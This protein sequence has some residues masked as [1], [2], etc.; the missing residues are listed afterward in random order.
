MDRRAEALDTDVAPQAGARGFVIAARVGLGI[1]VLLI[2]V[3]I[4]SR[5]TTSLGTIRT[6]SCGSALS[7]DGELMGP[8]CQVRLDDAQHQLY[9]LDL[10]WLMA[11]I[12]LALILPRR[13]RRVLLVGCLALGAVVL[14]VTFALNGLRRL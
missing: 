12:G 1:C 10:L 11:A 7:H 9:A 3:A 4:L 5:T 6:V 2:S 8:D 13:M 14:Y